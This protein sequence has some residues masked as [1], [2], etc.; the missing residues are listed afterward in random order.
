MIHLFFIGYIA[1][2]LYT[3]CAFSSV[4]T[5]MQFLLRHGNIS[6]LMAGM[7]H[8]AAQIVW[9]TLAILVMGL[10]K[11]FLNTEI[12]HYK[13]IAAGMLFLLSIKLLI[14]SSRNPRKILS[15]KSPNHL[16]GFLTV[17]FVAI[18]A[19]GRIIGYLALFILLGAPRIVMA[20]W[21]TKSYLLVGTLLGVASWWV[22]FSIIAEM[23]KFSPTK[24]QI[25]WLERLTVFVLMGVAVGLCFYRDSM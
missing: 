1:G 13:Y 7:G 3:F 20:S 23:F 25:I 24:Q 8:T 9:I 2:F 4:L 21:I 6:G 15:S 19:P 16:S 17:F 22:V 10:G 5:A 12:N 11:N 18:S 14:S